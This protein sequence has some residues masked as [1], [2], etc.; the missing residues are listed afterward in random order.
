MAAGSWN[1]FGVNLPEY[2]ITEKIG[3]FLGAPQTPQG[4]SNLSSVFAPQASN[5]P[6]FTPTPSMYSTVGNPGPQLPY[7]PPTPQPQPTQNQGGGNSQWDQFNSARG[8]GAYGGWNEQ[9]AWADFQATGG[10]GKIPGGGGGNGQ[11]DYSSQIS[12]IYN[13]LYQNLGAQE[14]YIQNTQLPSSLAELQS[15]REG[16]EQD[17]ADKQKEAEISI[18]RQTETLGGRQMSAM[19]EAKR[20]YQAL[21]RSAQARFGGSGSAGRAASEIVQT[22]FARQSGKLQQ[23]Y[24]EQF[25]KLQDYSQ[26]VEMFVLSE[27]RRISRESETQKLNIQQEAQ[28]R[29][30]Q[31]SQDKNSLESQKAQN[32]LELIR[33]S[34]ARINALSDA[35]QSALVEL[36]SWKA[37]ADY[38]AEQNYRQLQNLA[39][40]P[41]S[42]ENFFQG[43]LLASPGVQQQPYQYQ[44]GTKKDPYE[45]LN[46]FA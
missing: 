10:A 40:Q 35:R 44:T 11:P 22:E 36:S 43:S 1:L 26:K 21:N 38:V 27:G 25:G 24:A 32:K 13:P 9:A 39:P 23:A 3:S 5:Q 19:D 18:N 37:Q 42:F 12:D 30:F 14:Q 34:Q 16:L 33:E 29:L 7:N 31:I 41:T 45:D 8:A 6:T 20:N 2:G 17:L 46:P 28:K 15:S 4:G